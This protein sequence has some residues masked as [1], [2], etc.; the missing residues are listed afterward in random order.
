MI[1]PRLLPRTGE[2]AGTVAIEYALVLPV[3]LLFT[4][5]IMDASRLLWTNITLSHAA[6][7]AAR[8]WAINACTSESVQT[9]AATQAWGIDNVTFSTSAPACVSG[10]YTFQFIVPWFPQFSSSAPFGGTTLTLTAT[11]CYP[12]QPT[13]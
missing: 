6:E 11:A 9:Y 5:G 10:S 13:S 8:C 12:L 4:F 1:G 3:L 7:A 2:T